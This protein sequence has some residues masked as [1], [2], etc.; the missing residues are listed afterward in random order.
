[1]VLQNAMPGRFKG[2]HYYNAG[3]IFDTLMAMVKPMLSKKMQD[4]VRHLWNIWICISI[5]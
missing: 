3:P 4:R 2:F 1:M 5:W